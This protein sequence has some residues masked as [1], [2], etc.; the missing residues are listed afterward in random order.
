M[1]VVDT[2][3]LVAMLFR[4]AEAVEF[5]GI[6]DTQDRALVGAPTA[7]EF[8]LVVRG[9]ANDAVYEEALALLA[10]SPIE[11]VPFG[12]DHIDCAA[13]A[14]IDYGKGRHPAR[15]NFG[16]CLTYALAKTLDVPLLYKGEDFS[17]TDLRSAL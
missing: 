9:Q 14:F 7:F 15:L 1:I 3:A 4:E 13:R 12:P 6:I 17:Q 11:L 2:S 8:R 10:T 16:D 5:A